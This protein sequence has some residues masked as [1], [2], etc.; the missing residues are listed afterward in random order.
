M[1]E[2]MKTVTIFLEISSVVGTGLNVL[3]SF[4]RAIPFIGNLLTKSNRDACSDLELRLCI[5]IKLVVVKN[6]NQS[7]F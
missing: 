6:W 1:L 4:D 2:Q 7:K 5:M 3:R